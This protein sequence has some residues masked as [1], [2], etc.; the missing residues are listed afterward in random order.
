MRPHPPPQH[1]QASLPLRQC[2]T[3]HPNST[4]FPRPLLSRSVIFPS[5][6]PLVCRG[7]R[8]QTSDFASV[9]MSEGKS[10]WDSFAPGDAA[11]ATTD[12]KIQQGDVAALMM[13]GSLVPRP[14]PP[15]P[16]PPD[17]VAGVL[18]DG[19][20]EGQDQDESVAGGE[21]ELEI[22]AV[23]HYR[24]TLGGTLSGTWP[25]WTYISP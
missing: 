16:F 7:L 11:G 13:L 4:P 21:G 15:P 18:P 2:F 23:W 10:V 5:L 22:Q 14:E 1:T 9:G 8:L 17:V 19:Q 12:V 24:R 25:L 3:R 20:E 6:T